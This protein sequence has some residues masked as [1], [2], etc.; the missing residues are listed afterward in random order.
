[1]VVSIVAILSLFVVKHFINE[2]FK[3]K[4]PA[5]LPIELVVV[6]LA[7]LF[8]YLLDFNKKYKI[9]IVGKIP[10]G[11][12]APSLPAFKLTSLLI[13]DAFNIA[14]V[15][16]AMNISMAK[17]FA[18]KY[19]YNIRSNQELLAY[20]VGNFLSSWFS[21]FP[22]CVGL[23]RCAILEGTGGKTQLF[24]LISSIVVL[25]VIV[26]IGFLFRTLPIV[27]IILLLTLSFLLIFNILYNLK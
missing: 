6:V 21:G 1:L 4:L 25:V 14:L 15:S 26:G 22:S 11:F 2:R 23:S 12:P 9:A 13:G 17:L 8:S 3:K 24:S 10:L 27:N 19:D 20:G 7:T 18:K 5:P 16:F